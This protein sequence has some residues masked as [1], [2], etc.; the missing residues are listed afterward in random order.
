M[1]IRATITV[2]RA[3]ADTKHIS[4][5]AKTTNV[6][7]EAIAFVNPDSKNQW[8]Y[9]TTTLSDISFTLFEKNV[10]EVIALNESIGWGYEKPIVKQ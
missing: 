2:V 5:S 9:E 6:N 1:A 7:A 8:F 3:S 10:A 4:L